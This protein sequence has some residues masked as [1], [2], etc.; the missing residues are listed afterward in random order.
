M[1]IEFT[2]DGNPFGKQ[3]PYFTS[4]RGGS[5]GI[6]RKE[7]IL[8]ENIARETWHQVYKG[9]KEFEGDISIYIEAFYQ[10]PQSW[11]K[12]KQQAAE[13]D[14]IRPNRKGPLKADVDNV[15]KWIMDSLNP[16]KIGH[17]TLEGTGV[18][19]DD[20]QVVDLQIV[21]HYSHQP[22]TKVRIDARPKL[23]TNEIKKKVKERLKNG[24]I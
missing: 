11:P 16:N 1:I 21:S 23:D 3:R 12:W 22:R 5:R 19:R 15:C 9:K 24:S 20:G 7:T 4:F 13:F 18:Y 6:K 2:I 17:K 10:I 14:I 8:H